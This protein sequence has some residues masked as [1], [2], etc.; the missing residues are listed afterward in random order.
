MVYFLGSITPFWAKLSFVRNLHS[1][2]VAKFN[3]EN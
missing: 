3:I 1:V 2:F